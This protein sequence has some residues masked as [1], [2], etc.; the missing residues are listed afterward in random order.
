MPRAKALIRAVSPDDLA[1]PDQDGYRPLRG[2]A[3]GVQEAKRSPR[4]QLLLAQDGNPPPQADLTTTAPTDAA[5]TDPAAPTDQAPPADATAEPANP[6]ALAAFG[7]DQLDTALA[8]PGIIDLESL[9]R[10]ARAANLKVALPPSDMKLSRND[11]VVAGV[12][13]PANRVT[14]NGQAV[15]IKANGTFQHVVTLPDG[16]STL[17]IESS[18]DDGN[19]GR[20]EWPVEV[21][22]VQYFLLAF[23]EGAVGNADLRYAG[24]NPD[25]HMRLDNGAMLF[26]QTRLYFKGRLKGSELGTEFFQAYQATAHLDTGK[27]AEF[28]EMFSM[29]IQPDEYY[30]TYGDTSDQVQEVNARGK[31]YLLVEADK[32]YLK[33]ANFQANMQGIEF[34]DYARAF[35]GLDASFDKKLG[36][37]F[38]TKAR[39]LCGG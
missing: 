26:G 2:H 13:D 25:N 12:T 20:I 10:K 1:L 7:T 35:Y 16:A 22:S 17:T 36:D 37:D 4:F 24:A 32:S 21:A 31:L 33:F 39:G 34:F 5:P 23:A 27:Q 6:E 15:T 3:L 11:L 14:I 18:D 38:D 28:E 30:A 9:R 19:K 8:A 29:A